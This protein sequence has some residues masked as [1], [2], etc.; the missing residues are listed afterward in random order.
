M[1][2]HL[3]ERRLTEFVV[4]TT[5]SVMPNAATPATVLALRIVRRVDSL[6]RTPRLARLLT[7]SVSGAWPTDEQWV[8]ARRACRTVA[9]VS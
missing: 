7:L 4:V 2:W 1:G 8:E 5:D 6:R 3:N 9:V